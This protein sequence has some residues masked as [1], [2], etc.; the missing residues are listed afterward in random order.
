M[1]LFVSLDTYTMENLKDIEKNERVT[2]KIDIFSLPVFHNF[3]ENKFKTKNYI[4]DIF[5][6]LFIILIFICISIIFIC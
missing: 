2:R 6:Y 3:D 4:L 5:Y 1:L